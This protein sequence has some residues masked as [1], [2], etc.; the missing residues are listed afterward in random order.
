MTNT[1]YL[2]M[3]HGLAGCLCLIVSHEATIKVLAKAAD[4]S[5][6]KLG[7]IRSWAHYMSVGSPQVLAGYWLRDGIFLPCKLLHSAVR[8]SWFP[9]EKVNKRGHPRWKLQSVL[10]SGLRSDYFC[11]VQ[12]IR[13]KSTSPAHI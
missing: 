13:S 10:I 5:K 7:K 3:Q 2:S 6:F 12:F 8:D 9:S 4:I 11:H 1:D